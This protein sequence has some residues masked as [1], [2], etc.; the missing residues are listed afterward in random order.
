MAFLEN[1]EQSAK[2]LDSAFIVI[3]NAQKFLAHS[4]GPENITQ[5]I[6]PYFVL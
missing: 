6:F 2:A 1:P 4:L 5:A 3:K